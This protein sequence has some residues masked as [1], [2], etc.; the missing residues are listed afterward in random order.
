M[1]TKGE[2]VYIHTYERDRLYILSTTLLYDGKKK[3][4]TPA[5]FGPYHIYSAIRCGVRINNYLQNMNSAEC[6][7]SPA[8]A[9]LQNRGELLNRML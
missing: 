7:V 5:S 2:H 4:T 9:L 3:T 8:C 1:M 6:G